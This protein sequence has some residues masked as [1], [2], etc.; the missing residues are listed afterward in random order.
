MYS[1][2]GLTPD[3]NP[4]ARRAK[5][6]TMPRLAVVMVTLAAAPSHGQAPLTLAEAEAIAIAAEPGGQ[7]LEARAD[8]L[9]AQAVVAG[10]LP[11]PML[12][13][14]VNN[15]PLESGGFATEGM[16][17]AGVGLRQALPRGRTRAATTAQFERLAQSMSETASARQRSVINATRDAWLSAYFWNRAHTLVSESRPYF[18][19]LATVTRS[20]YAVGRKSQQ[21]VLHAE[22][23]LSR[24]DDRLIDIERQRATAIASLGQWVGRDAERPIADALPSWAPPAPID[25]LRVALQSNPMLRAAA[26]QIA[27]REAAV[28]VAEQRSKPEWALELGYSYREGRLMSGDPRSDF[29]SLNVTV[30]LPFVRKRSVDSTLTAALGEERAAR[31]M[32]EQLRRDID[33]RLGSEYAR[34]RD[35]SRRLDV[36]E[37]RILNQA[38]DRA[39][40]AL[41]A[42]QNDRGDFADVMRAAIDNLNT[43][44]EYV[45]LQTERAKAWAALAN[46]GGISP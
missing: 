43:R 31:A 18:D 9:S 20:L 40:A 26:S 24:L 30:G 15:Y 13:L 36:Y 38:R 34:W 37:S 6:L 23:E 5:S 45:R 22:L 39:E 2:F 29:V 32:F 35:L 7:A 44:I 25:E 4:H 27:A 19:D 12:R 11:D 42:Y 8:A 10:A 16:T 46:L 1:Y 17:N 41:L 21:D 14:G 33:A 3:H 28:V